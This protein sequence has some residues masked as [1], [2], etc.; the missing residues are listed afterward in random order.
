MRARPAALAAL[1]LFAPVL[2]GCL[3]LSG[4]AV[5]PAAAPDAVPLAGEAP[6]LWGGSLSAA[7]SPQ[8]PLAAYACWAGAPACEPEDARCEPGAC[9][10]VPFDVPADAGAGVALEVSIRWPT[11]P[12]PVFA[13]RVED[14]AGRVV[15]RASH[16]YPATTGL[17]AWLEAPAPGRYEAVVSILR[18]S[19]SYEGVAQLERLP[20]P[21]A[22]ALLPDLAPLEPTDL[23]L[24]TPD[25]AGASYFAFPVPG[26]R[27]AAE[28]LGAKGCRLDEVVELGARRCLRFSNAVANLGAGPL[29]VRLDPVAMR[30]VQRVHHADGSVEERPAGA[31]E[32]H[33]T[34]A[35]WHNAAA[36]RFLVRAWDD[37]AGAAGEPLLDGR[38]TGICFADT[39]I[40]TLGLPGTQPPR[41]DGMGCLS[42]TRHGEW[43]TGLTPG[44]YDLYARL[45]SEQFVEVSGLAD[46]DYAVC[47]VTNED[48]AL[49]ESSLSNNEAC[50]PFRLRG[51]DVE[52]LRPA[53]YHAMPSEGNSGA[54]YPEPS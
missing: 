14:A 43:R 37:A 4:S 21:D 3:G 1:L 18:G 41:E 46:G 29:D 28:A 2:T 52:L 12:A 13:L 16:S 27:E 30:Y 32:W 50:T 10:R 19:T 47:V 39:G 48:G 33:A 45:L 7:G 38:K 11:E 49:L 42:P 40:T 22:G 23:T 35:H 51:D 5:E 31:A 54:A 25:Y 17:T 24:E 6:A 9:D 15:A 26:V 8:L 44:W 20:P 53:P 34:H 36:T